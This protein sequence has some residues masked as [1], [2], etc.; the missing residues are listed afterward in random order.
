MRA[1]IIPVG[2][3]V[4]RPLVALGAGVVALL[5]VGIWG[6]AEYGPAVFFETLASGL[7][8]CL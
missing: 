7:A 3:P 8:S 2:H 1:G 5:A 4:P 6:W